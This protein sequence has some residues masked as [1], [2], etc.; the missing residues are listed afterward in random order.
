MNTDL[1]N[2]E[3][4]TVEPQNQPPTDEEKRLF[5]IYNQINRSKDPGEMLAVIMT[6]TEMFS[7]GLLQANTVNDRQGKNRYTVTHGTYQINNNSLDLD[8]NEYVQK[9][10]TNTITIVLN[11]WLQDKQ[12]L[13]SN[14]PKLAAGMESKVKSLYLML[15]FTN[16]YEIIENLTTPP[17]IKKVLK[18]AFKT[19]HELAIDAFDRFMDQLEEL[20]EYGLIESLSSVGDQIWGTPATKSVAAF[21]YYVMSHFTT[22]INHDNEAKI[23]EIYLAERAQWKKS[24]K[25]G[26]V[27]EL[28][29][30]FKMTK[31]QY[32]TGK[33]TLYNELTNLMNGEDQVMVL[34]SLL[35]EN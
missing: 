19:M 32:S 3:T 11:S 18:T 23:Y 34:N 15:F 31:D 6:T 25:A 27:G 29:D 14:K 35:N 13:P 26:N 7:Y 10:F 16:N 28:Y 12:E 20:G 9:R 5:D 4:P 21:R 30:I 1:Q 2:V 24:G 8:V 33:R 17:Y 22:L